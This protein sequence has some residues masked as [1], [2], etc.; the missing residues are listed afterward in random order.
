MDWIT[1]R[2]Q[3][4]PKYYLDKLVK[5]IGKDVSSFNKLSREKEPQKL[6]KVEKTISGGIRVFKGKYVVRNSKQLL[7][8]DD[9]FSHDFVELKLQNSK[10]IA[11]R[12][13][14]WKFEIKTKWNEETLACN[15]YIEDGE[16]LSISILSQRIIGDFLFDD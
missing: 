6:F 3:C 15:L 5:I 9:E 4:T 11:S 7:V 12:V 1:A 8:K 16:F 14:Q 13:D 10:L 2:Y